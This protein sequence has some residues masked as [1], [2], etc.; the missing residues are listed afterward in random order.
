[1]T[2]DDYI[3]KHEEILCAY[4]EGFISEEQ[5]EIKLANLKRRNKTFDPAPENEISNEDYSDIPFY[6]MT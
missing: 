4:E 1:M 3:V 2:W 5:M 6:Y